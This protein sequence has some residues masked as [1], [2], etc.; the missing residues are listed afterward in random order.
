MEAAWQVTVAWHAD[1]EGVGK[2]LRRRSWAEAS[3]KSGEAEDAECRTA[4]VLRR[5][6]G[7]A[8]IATDRQHGLLSAGVIRFTADPAMKLCAAMVAIA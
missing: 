4:E 2:L 8:G 1:V 5:A 3:P 6:D 7:C